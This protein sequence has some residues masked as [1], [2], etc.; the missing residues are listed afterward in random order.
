[1]HCKSTE[2]A[3]VLTNCWLKF[4]QQWVGKAFIATRGM[5]MAK[6]LLRYTDKF[7][8]DIFQ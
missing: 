3:F 6:K 2:E 7:L 5:S 4:K 8:S 1:M